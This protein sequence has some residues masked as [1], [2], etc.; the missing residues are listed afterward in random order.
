[1]KVKSILIA[2]LVLGSFYS[3]SQGVGLTVPE[4]KSISPSTEI[5]IGTYTKYR[6][7]ER[8]FYYGEYHL[9]RRNGFSDMGQIYLRFGLSYLV[10]KYFEVTAGVVNPYYWAPNPE[11]PNIDK[12]VPQFRGW[13]QF[14]FVMP[15]ERLKLYHQIRT[16]Q[17]FKRD[18]EKGAHFKLTHRFRYKITMYYPLTKP[19][20]DP[21][22]LFLSFYEEV[23][24]QAGKSIIYD[25]LE[26]NRIFLGVGYIIDENWQLQTGYQWTFRHDNSPFAYQSRNIFRLSAYHN[27]DFFGNRKP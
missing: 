10:S 15:F 9:R 18:Y 11:V 1:M 5:W 13:Q 3:Y 19:H 8:L 2:F 23:F 17:R 6:I 20:L 21:Q 27:I 24:I 12:V 22:T 14:L 16:E 7:G 26:D 25:H 4:K